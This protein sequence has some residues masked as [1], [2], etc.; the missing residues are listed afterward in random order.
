[1]NSSD[2]LEFSLVGGDASIELRSRQIQRVVV[3]ERLVASRGKV[4][5]TVDRDVEFFGGA[6]LVE[7]L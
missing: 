4:E 1:M 5:Q 6:E 7:V 3:V 2:V